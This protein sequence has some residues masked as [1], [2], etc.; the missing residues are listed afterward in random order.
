MR[1][2]IF[3]SNQPELY[4]LRW[5]PNS[6]SLHCIFSWVELG[7]CWYLNSTCRYCLHIFF[8]FL[9]L[10]MISLG[11]NFVLFSTIS[12]KTHSCRLLKKTLTTEHACWL[13]D[14]FY[15]VQSNRTFFLKKFP[16]HMHRPQIDQLDTYRFPS[17]G[18][19]NTSQEHIAIQ[20][21]VKHIAYLSLRGKVSFFCFFEN[22]CRNTK[23]LTKIYI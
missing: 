5:C 18:L 17:D 7:V 23:W 3:Q 11:H 12:I 9:F 1:M 21:E 16:L 6:T 8:L 13:T 14:A 19:M 15:S 22:G 10:I 2:L 4:G 20:A